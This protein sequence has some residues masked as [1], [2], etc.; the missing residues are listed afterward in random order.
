MIRLGPRPTRGQA[1]LPGRQT[2]RRG[3]S[4]ARLRQYQATSGSV[5]DQGSIPE[6][7]RRAAGGVLECWVATRAARRPTTT[8]RVSSGSMV[9]SFDRLRRPH[10][11]ELAAGSIELSVGPA[12]G[13]RIAT[14]WRNRHAGVTYRTER[15]PAAG[16]AAQPLQEPASRGL[17]DPQRGRER[18]SE[19]RARPG[20]DRGRSEEAVSRSGRGA[21]RQSGVPSRRHRRAGGRRQTHAGAAQPRSPGRAP[22]PRPGPPPGSSRF[23]R[24]RV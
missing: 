5:P 22:Q 9:G 1:C 4:R 18:M 14:R 7:G 6:V 3:I 2:G 17:M 11:R 13:E 23:C 12:C 15:C 20:V 19:Q 8:K 10:G 24:D 21:S 16:G